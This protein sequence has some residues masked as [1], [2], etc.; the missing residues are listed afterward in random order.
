MTASR[1]DQPLAE[2]G[3]ALD[4]IGGAAELAEVR[5]FL[6]G[7]ERHQAAMALD[8]LERIGARA[9]K[10]LRAVIEPYARARP[11]VT[12]EP[13]E[14]LRFADWRG[15][16]GGLVSLSSYRSPAL[17]GGFLVLIEAE[18]V[19]R[20]V[21]AFYGGTGGINP[22]APKPTEFTA[23]EARVAGRLADAVTDVLA[24]AWG[25]FAPLQ[26]ALGQR[27]TTAAAA[28]LVRDDEAIVVQR[29]AIEGGTTG[30]ARIDIVYPLAALRQHAG[31]A[32]VGRQVDASPA[33][34]A[35]RAAL[36]DALTEVQLP[37]RSVLARPS[38]SVDQLLALKPGD[39]IPISVGPRV[40]LLVA[41]RRVAEGTIGE[42]E[43]RAAL[44]IEGIG[45]DA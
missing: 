8:G 11:Q 5:P 33:D 13:A 37:V 27:E 22:L 30:A 18:W 35:F 4:E 25:E 31:L 29:F 2:L 41:N 21:D 3:E 28:Q 26:P 45:R 14:T 9:A 7:G 36:A 38:L 15:Q 23:G 20:L 44:M 39:V 10:A 1:H 40:P 12:A 34:L 32:G 42:Q 16:R 19:T 43:G 6:L 17:K 24:V